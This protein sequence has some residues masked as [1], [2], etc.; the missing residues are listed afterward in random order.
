MGATNGAHEVKGH[1]GGCH[2]GAVRFEVE[3]DLR[4]PA[5]RCNCSVCT[6]VSPT[7]RIVK[8]AAFRLTQ[9]EESL[10]VY[11]WGA[12]VSKRFFCGSCGVHCFGRGHLEELGG[13]YVSVNV[14]CLDGF[15]PALAHPAFRRVG[16]RRR[17][18]APRYYC[19]TWRVKLPP[20]RSS[21]AFMSARNWRC[22]SP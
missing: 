21:S 1:A 6:K 11:E 13:D 20:F 15:D 2:C 10:S 12:K 9:G 17:E 19:P 7:G 16:A 8:P 5:M 3:L 14:N 18:R 4:E 22:T